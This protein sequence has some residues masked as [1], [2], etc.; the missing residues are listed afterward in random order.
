M[1]GKKLKCVLG[2]KTY[3]KSQGILFLNLRGVFKMNEMCCVNC[4]WFEEC[5]GL[6]EVC[7]MYDGIVEQNDTY[8]SKVSFAKEYNSYLE[9]FYNC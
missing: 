6:G 1:Y 5:D 9:G 7:D 8:D 3:G 4:M 2:Y